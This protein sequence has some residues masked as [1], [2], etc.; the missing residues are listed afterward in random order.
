MISILRAKESD[1]ELI[2]KLGQQTFIESHGSSASKENI[3]LYL[4]QKYHP[5]I[6][7]DELK[8]SQNIYH[9]I[10]YKKI[11]V[12]YSKIILNA[13][14]PNI[15]GKNVTKLERLY[16]LKEFYNLKLG[17]TL[18]KFIA[19]FSKLNQQKGLWLFVWTE[20]QKALHFYSQIGFKIIGRHDFKISANHSN[21]NHQMLL[22]Y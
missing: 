7:Q 22:K 19:E 2:S 6:V 21:P 3:D 9:L 14:H 16:L 8:D 10:Y 15:E 20:N 1:F 13:P 18:F 17:Y 11:A 12:G 5:K 4:N